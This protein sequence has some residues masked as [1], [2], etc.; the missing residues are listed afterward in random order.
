MATL[1]FLLWYISSN[2][3]NNNICFAPYIIPIHSYIHGSNNLFCASRRLA[4]SA[5]SRSFVAS[6]AAYV[7][8]PKAGFFLPLLKK[9]Q[10]FTLIFLLYVIFSLHIIWLFAWFSCTSWHLPCRNSR[11]SWWSHTPHT[12]TMIIIIIII[13]IIISNII[14]ALSSNSTSHCTTLITLI[15]GKNSVW[16]TQALH[17]RCVSPNVLQPQQFIIAQ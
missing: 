10:C 7:S 4:F 1:F 8:Q 5:P 17:E 9:I 15:N 12:I 2:T 3:F 11:I 16:N 14:P 13:I 6:P